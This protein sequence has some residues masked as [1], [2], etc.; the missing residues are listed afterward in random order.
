MRFGENAGPS[1][2]G[3]FLEDAVAGVGLGL[4][5]VFRL[6]EIGSAVAAADAGF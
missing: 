2:D 5:E 1:P 4:D 3:D 6:I